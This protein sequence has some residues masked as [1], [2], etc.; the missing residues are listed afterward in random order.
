MN[1]ENKMFFFLD[2]N[3]FFI[4][5]LIVYIKIEIKIG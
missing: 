1:N 3:I 5:I 2:L 4:N